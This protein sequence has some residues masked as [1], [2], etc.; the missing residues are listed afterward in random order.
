MTAP[1]PSG[2]SIAG[3]LDLTATVA[4]VRA[5]AAEAL[6]RR[7]R[8][9]VVVPGGRGPLPLFTA[10]REGGDVSAGWRIHLSDERCVPP[11]D[12]R[13]NAPAIAAALGLAPDDVRLVAPPWSGDPAADAQV[14]A[15]RVAAVETFDLVVLGLG[16]DGH[17]ASLFPDDP[18][19]LAPDATDALAVQ[20]ADVD[21]AERIT[22]SASR[23]RRAR[24]IVFVVAGDD[25]DA[26]FARVVA[27]ADGAFPTAALAGPP[28]WLADLRGG[29]V[30][31]TRR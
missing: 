4:L 17:T 7:R 30:R 22:L 27:G 9:E 16:A 28:C 25:K 6:A 31:V 11:D 21:P 23:L 14:Y 24:T 15:Q 20:V 10:L 1:P 8:F 2:S 26:A 29:S 3:V 18:T 19:G 12:P 13:R 5:H